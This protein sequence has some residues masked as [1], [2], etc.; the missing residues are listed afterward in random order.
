MQ[1]SCKGSKRKTKKCWHFLA[2]KS[3]NPPSLSGLKSFPP[4][5]WFRCCICCIGGSFSSSVTEEE[6]VHP[7]LNTKLSPHVLPCCCRCLFGIPR[8]NVGKLSRAETNPSFRF[9][10]CKIKGEF[11]QDFTCLWNKNLWK[12]WK[13]ILMLS[14]LPFIPQ[15]NPSCVYEPQRLCCR[16]S[17]R[18]GL[19][20]FSAAVR[21]I[22]SLERW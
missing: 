1:L 11:S 17:P 19:F 2:V 6:A 12:K 14:P 4:S 5:I 16:I 3:N 7:N 13:N 20:G 18:P 10:P 9:N 21:N 8:I 15:H 22:C